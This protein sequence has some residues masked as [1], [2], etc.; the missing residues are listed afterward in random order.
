[1]NHSL[2]SILAASAAVLLA[3]SASADT[4]PPNW[5]AWVR[6]PNIKVCKE[7]V[8]NSQNHL[9]RVENTD[10][11][12]FEFDPTLTSAG[13]L[14]ADKL[15]DWIRDSC[16]RADAHQ[17]DPFTARWYQIDLEPTNT[18]VKLHSLSGVL[19]GVTNGPGTEIKSMTV[20]TFNGRP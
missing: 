9:V 8:I 14:P 1:M 19:K 13:G 18:G 2:K 7:R 17:N 15:I 10:G 11:T 4:T 3:G 20:P 6:G 5:G 16:I 12:D